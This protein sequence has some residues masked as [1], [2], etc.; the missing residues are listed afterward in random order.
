MSI[1]LDFKKLKES[2]MQNNKY[3]YVSLVVLIVLLAEIKEVHLD[4]LE[5]APERPKI[6]RNKHELVDYINKINHYYG[7]VGR[8]VRIIFDLN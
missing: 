6:F 5:G 1:Y 3:K 7:V 2:K 4:K 8:P